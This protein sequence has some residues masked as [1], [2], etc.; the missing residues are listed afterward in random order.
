MLYR[1]KLVVLGLAASWLGVAGTQAFTFVEDFSTDPVAGGRFSITTGDASRFVYT[2]QMLEAQYDT[3][4]PTA[5]YLHPLG[6]TFTQNDPFTMSFDVNWRS[7]GFSAGIYGA[8]L[9]FGALN[10]LTTG[11]DRAG[12]G[13]SGGDTYDIVTADYF[14][15]LEAL[16]QYPSPSL[17]PTI[18][19]SAT[20]SNFYNH[21]NF[22]FGSETA[23]DAEFP[24]GLPLNQ[25]LRFQ[26][27]YDPTQKAISLQVL[28]NGTALLINTDGQTGAPFDTDPTTIQSF[29]PSGAVFSIDSVGVPLWQD[30]FINNPDGAV[31]ATADFSRI[32]FSSTI[33]EPRALSTW[34]MAGMSCLL[35]LRRRNANGASRS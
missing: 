32:E 11:T 7:Q 25:A 2:N 21:L 16:N 6:Q 22:S 1:S 9:A 31:I 14:P 27:T 17:G 28:T 15:T 18:I 35:W 34:A 30:T 8:S 33:P 12:G 23:L 24:N 26:M 5:K 13:P 19:T 3:S 10:S 20:D 4:Q 29:L